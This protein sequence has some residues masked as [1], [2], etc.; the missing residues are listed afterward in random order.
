M[1]G[2]RIGG[3]PLPRNWPTFDQLL[4][5]LNL[6]VK[7]G[8]IITRKLSKNG[9]KHAVAKTLGDSAKTHGPLI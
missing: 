6:D 4:L 7:P 8:E 3:P 2:R 1:R 5:A 9:R